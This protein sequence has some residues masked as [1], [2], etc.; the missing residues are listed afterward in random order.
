MASGSGGG[1]SDFASFAKTAISTAQK[2]IDKVL[3]ISPE[4]CDSAP[5]AAGSSALPLDAE[6]QDDFFGS[7]GLPPQPQA[8]SKFA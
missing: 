2:R 8:L 4:D 7:F 1:W 6:L 3:E 5:S